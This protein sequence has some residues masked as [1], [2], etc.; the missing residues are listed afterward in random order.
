MA[1]IYNNNLDDE[2]L[3]GLKKRMV[4]VKRDLS[5]LQ[6]EEEKLNYWIEFMEKHLLEVHTLPNSKGV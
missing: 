3:E 1:K 2:F 6:Q 4:V 5:Y